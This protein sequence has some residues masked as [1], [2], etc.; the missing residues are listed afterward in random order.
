MKLRCG[1]DVLIIDKGKT[2]LGRVEMISTNQVSALI[3]FDGMIGG[4]AGALP[5]MR[6]DRA[7]GLYRSIIDGT[8]VTLRQ[9]AAN[10]EGND[11]GKAT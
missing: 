2:V 10:Q 3:S 9:P 11:S 4:H 1:D 7:L 6:H 5:L 8:E